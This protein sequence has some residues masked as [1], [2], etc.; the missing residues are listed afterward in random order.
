MYIEKIKQTLAEQ[1]PFRIEMHAH[2]SPASPC[3]DATAEELIDIYHNAGYH[4]L[5]LTNHFVSFLE[6]ERTVEE[7]LQD[8]FRA[9]KQA[10]K[11]GMKVYLGAELRFDEYSNDYLLYGVN[12]DILETAKGYFE[13]GLECYYTEAKPKESVLI[14]AH[15]FRNN[16]TLIDARF[17]DGYE[18]FNMHTGH[19]PRTADAICRAKTSGKSVVT[20]GTDFHHPNRQ[21]PS[22]ALRVREL[23]KDS[24]ALAQLLKSGDYLFEAEDKTLI[25]P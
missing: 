6:N 21:R 18:T 1:Y 22:G 11:Y 24:F 8:Y 9:E 25:L 5:V 7:Y 13:K 17:V 23:P 20:I 2:S 3:A 16:M 14:Q 15:P 4:A 10:E 12:Q 19:N